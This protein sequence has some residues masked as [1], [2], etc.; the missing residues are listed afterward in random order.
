MLASYAVFAV[1]CLPKQTLS[2][3][4]PVL[5][6]QDQAR[7]SHRLKV[8]WA[9]CDNWILARQSA[10]LTAITPESLATA[11][12]SRFL[13]NC[14]QY[15]HVSTAIQTRDGLDLVCRTQAQKG[16]STSPPRKRGVQGNRH[17]LATLDS[18]FRGN[19]E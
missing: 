9:E 15:L 1:L 6:G 5:S 16:S 2:P 8:S 12:A 4:P 11:D 18:R 7:F 14:Q 19:D 17:S 10:M 13:L 3:V